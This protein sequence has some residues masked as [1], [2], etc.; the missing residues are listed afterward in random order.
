MSSWRTE[1]ED[2]LDVGEIADGILARA[3]RL[4]LDSRLTDEKAAW[5]INALHLLPSVRREDGF[6][7]KLKFIRE[8]EE[9][10]WAIEDK[11][12]P[13]WEERRK[14]QAVIEITRG[15]GMDF[16]LVSQM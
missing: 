4:A 5:L 2:P 11:F 15:Q 7:L 14:G 16:G 10:E 9:G 3:G 8:R 12:D 1:E 6:L 13:I